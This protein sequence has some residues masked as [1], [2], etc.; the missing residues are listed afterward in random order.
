M[1]RDD[2]IRF[3]VVASDGR[4]SDVWRVWNSRNDVYVAPRTKGGEFKISLHESG[5]WR[6]AFTEKNLPGCEA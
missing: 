1:P 4:W 2:K 5:K 3:Q 6:L